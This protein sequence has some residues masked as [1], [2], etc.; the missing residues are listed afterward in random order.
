[1]SEINRTDITKVDLARPLKTERGGGLMATL[2]NGVTFGARVYR[3][4]VAVDLTG[5]TAKGYFTKPDGSTYNLTGTVEGNTVTVS[6]NS[7]CLFK[8]GR[9]MLTIKLTQSN[10][11][12]TLRVINGYIYGSMADDHWK[13]VYT[14]GA[15]Q[16]GANEV[17]LTWT[18]NVE[19]RLNWTVYEIV[20]GEYQ[21][22]SG[23]ITTQIVL[24]DVAEGEHSYCV[25]PTYQGEEGNYST[26]AT[27][28]VTA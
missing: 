15:S 2:D 17:T 25:K 21:L 5:C 7:A 16:T 9:Y 20:G 26:A 27:V 19:S 14:I 8:P 18:G 22:V 28:Y 24:Y 23:A 3:D 4:G 6:V 1:M 10:V 11:T 12:Q 13:D